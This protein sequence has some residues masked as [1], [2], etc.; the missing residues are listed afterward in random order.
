MCQPGKW[1]IMQRDIQYLRE[2][3]V[4]EVMYNIDLVNNLLFPNAD[5]IKRMWSMWRKLVQSAPLLY[6]NMMAIMTCKG[7]EE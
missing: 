3:A 6:A 2:L 1:T 5:S 7:G 4:L